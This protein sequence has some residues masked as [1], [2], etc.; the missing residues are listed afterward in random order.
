MGVEILPGLTDE[1]VEKA[2]AKFGFTFP[3]ELREFLQVGLPTK[4]HNWRELIKDSVMVGFEADTVSQQL[5]WNATPE[6][7]EDVPDEI[8]ELVGSRD[9]EEVKKQASLHRLVPIAGHRMMPS[10]PH[11][12]GLPV[13]SMHQCSDLAL[14]V[15]C[16]TV[17]YTSPHLIDR[18]SDRTA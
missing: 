10:V 18:E 3:P 8:W 2:E 4:W 17:L 15:P 14:A 1:E 11:E 7:E 13:L 5:L 6:E 12:C 9:L 16:C